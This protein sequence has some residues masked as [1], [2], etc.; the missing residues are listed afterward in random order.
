MQKE[1]RTDLFRSSPASYQ[2]QKWDNINLSTGFCHH[3]N[4]T[5]PKKH[6]PNQRELPFPTSLKIQKAVIKKKKKGREFT[7]STQQKLIKLF[8]VTQQTL[9]FVRWCQVSEITS[10]MNEKIITT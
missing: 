4:N 3:Q 8:D 1:Q 5:P 6:I 9:K 10:K 2:T 7:H